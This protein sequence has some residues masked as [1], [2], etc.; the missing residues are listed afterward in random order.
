VN[1]L[2]YDIFV[3]PK[4]N[5]DKGLLIEYDGSRFHNNSDESLTREAR[6]EQN[7]VNSGY[8]FL[9][10]KETDWKKVNRENTK[11][12]MVSLLGIVS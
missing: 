10:I 9:R 4:N 12:Q 11:K 1:K 7:A 3:Q 5:E 6:K 2:A 8:E